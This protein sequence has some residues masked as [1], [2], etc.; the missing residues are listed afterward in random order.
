MCLLLNNILDTLGYF[1]IFTSGRVGLDKVLF[2]V[3][4]GSRSEAVKPPK[5]KVI[6]ATA[7]LLGL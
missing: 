7:L 3:A 6:N 5:A 2:I 1:F 4:V